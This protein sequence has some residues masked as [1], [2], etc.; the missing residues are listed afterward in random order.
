[1][2]ENIV[3]KVL[4]KFP[5]KRIFK[6]KIVFGNCKFIQGPTLLVRTF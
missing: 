5:E 4:Y 3:G 6:K 1:M 2:L